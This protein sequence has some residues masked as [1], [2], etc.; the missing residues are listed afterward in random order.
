MGAG[1]HWPLVC[2]I[3]YL[4]FICLVFGQYGNKFEMDGQERHFCQNKTMKSAYLLVGV[5]DSLTSNLSL[6][7]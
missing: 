5:E 6:D 4:C 3:L 7:G 2:K 1:L